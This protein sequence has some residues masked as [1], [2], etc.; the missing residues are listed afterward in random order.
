MA[1]MAPVLRI[2][3]QDL[4]SDAAPATPDPEKKYVERLVKLIPAEIVS[5]YLAGKSAIQAAFPPTAAANAEQG[6]ISENVYWIGWTISCFVS[7]VIVRA[8][9]TSDSNQGAK[10][11]WPAVWIAASSF[12]IW[13][14][15]LGDAF[16]R[17]KIF[18]RL[19]HGIWEP[20]LAMLIVFAWTLVIPIVYRE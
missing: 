19:E 6:F 16:A 4:L 11:E 13:V 8:W 14:Y 7:V 5:V 20:L 3:H 9:A 17:P 10:P 1:H 15:S 12:L 2:K 18:F